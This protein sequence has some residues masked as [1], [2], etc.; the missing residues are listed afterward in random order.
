VIIIGPLFIKKAL[1]YVME[2]VPHY[3]IA[4]DD[5]FADKTDELILLALIVESLQV[6]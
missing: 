3:H 5:V 1:E 2:L 4:N 6:F